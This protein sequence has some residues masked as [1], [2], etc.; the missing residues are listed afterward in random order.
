LSKLQGTLGNQIIRYDEDSLGSS[1]IVQQYSNLF[2]SVADAVIEF[3]FFKG[4]RLPTKVKNKT[5]EWSLGPGLSDIAA[6]KGADYLLLINTLDEIGSTGRK[7]LQAVGFLAGVWI[8]AGVHSG[9]AG[10][11]DLHT[12]ELVWLNAD[13]QM[14]GDVRTTEGA[15]KRIGQ[16]LE[17]FPG[18]AKAD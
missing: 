4:G 16:L 13:R 5:F 11:V 1:P 14:G 7:M 18:R 2:S 8:K 15:E 6:L 12:G 3:Q 9:Y 17:G 10:L